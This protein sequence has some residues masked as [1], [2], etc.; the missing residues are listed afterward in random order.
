MK[1]KYMC[2]VY[3]CIINRVKFFKNTTAYSPIALD[4]FKQGLANFSIKYEIVNIFS[5]TGRR[6]PLELLNFVPIVWKQP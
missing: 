5:S 6:S 3:K 4:P 2:I 1:C